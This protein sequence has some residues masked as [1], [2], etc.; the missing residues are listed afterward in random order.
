MKGLEM[1]GTF[2][3]RKWGCSKMQEKIDSYFLSDEE[4]I[5]DVLKRSETGN[6]SFNVFDPVEELKIFGFVDFQR[7]S[8]AL[9]SLNS[10]RLIS[11]RSRYASNSKGKIE[12]KT[13]TIGLTKSFASSLKVVVTV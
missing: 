10:K 6:V 5:L 11:I 7:C 8:A 2:T 9:A 1:K 12:V 3:R 13:K 4:K